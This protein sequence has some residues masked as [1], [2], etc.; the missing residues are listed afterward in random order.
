MMSL[1]VLIELADAFD[2]TGADFERSC[3]E[4]G[5]RRTEVLPVAGP[6]S[7]AIARA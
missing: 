4:A 7:A 5:F 6:T 2:L 1:N 3:K